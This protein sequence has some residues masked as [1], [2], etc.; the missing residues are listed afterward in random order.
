RA[1]RVSDESS[2]HLAA[3]VTGGHR[4]Q[5]R[6][7][8]EDEEMMAFCECPYFQETGP[9]KHLWAAVLEADRRGALAEARNAKNL[10]L[11]DDLDLDEVDATLF[12]LRPPPSPPRVPAWQQ[13]LNSIRREIEQRKPLAP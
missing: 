10:T 13:Q 7:S 8:Y 9:C 3:L 4:Y 11:E 2:T 12:S 1:V 5:V 6:L